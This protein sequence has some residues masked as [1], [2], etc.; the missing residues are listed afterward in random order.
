MTRR[1]AL[2]TAVTVALGAPMGA[3]LADAKGKSDP[4]IKV[5]KDCL[6]H[7]KLKRHYSKRQLKQAQ[8]TL[9]KHRNLSQYAG[10]GK[11]IKKALKGGKHR[12]KH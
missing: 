1:I 3:P 9:R 2:I 7:G 5:L 11:I 12:R 6:A 8:K 10:C 4:G